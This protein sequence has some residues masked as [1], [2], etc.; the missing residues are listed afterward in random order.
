MSGVGSFRPTQSPPLGQLTVSG[1]E[2]PNRLPLNT[3]AL[4]Q[5]AVALALT[6]L[7]Y[8][9]HT[10]NPG[11]QEYS[12]GPLDLHALLSATL[13][14]A[15]PLLPEAEDADV[16]SLVWAAAV[17]WPVV[18]QSGAG[19]QELGVLVAEAAAPHRK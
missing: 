17:C 11:S 4:A 6:L 1:G 3:Y 12:S 8:Q 5:L 10:C 13:E 9:P 15:L 14:A 19:K 2:Q 18:V 7:P 16:A